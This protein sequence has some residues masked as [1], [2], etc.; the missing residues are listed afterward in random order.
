MCF[1]DRSE[2]EVETV[3]QSGFRL[4][5]RMTW[6]FPSLLGSP[7][8]GV[9]HLIGIW[10]LHGCAYFSIIMSLWYSLY[11]RIQLYEPSTSASLTHPRGG[12]KWGV[13][14]WV[15]LTSLL[16]FFPHADF[17]RLYTHP[18][19]IT[20]I[21]FFCLSG[22]RCN[23]QYQRQGSIEVWERSDQ[24]LVHIEILNPFWGKQGLSGLGGNWIPIT[25]GRDTLCLS[26]D[27]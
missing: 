10:T 11:F 22:V 1:Q 23:S 16:T 15:Q 20:P 6:A 27:L 8:S 4:L 26:R 5:C 17:V 21:L 18:V 19:D 2:L 25:H 12:V 24:W 7:T 13:G 3:V 9:T 14:R